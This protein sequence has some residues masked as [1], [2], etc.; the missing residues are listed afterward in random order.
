MTIALT[1]TATTKSLFT[2]STW[3]YVLLLH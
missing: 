2:H 3:H 1:R